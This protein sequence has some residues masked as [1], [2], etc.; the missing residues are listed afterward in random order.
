MSHHCLSRNQ[1]QRF[2]RPASQIANPNCKEKCNP[3][4]LR[5]VVHTS[6]IGY[7][8]VLG[9][10]SLHKDLYDSANIN[11]GWCFLNC[12]PMDCL[13]NDNVECE[14]GGNY[15]GWLVA[16]NSFFFLFLAVVIVSS[17]LTAQTIR[18]RELRGQRW[19]ISNANSRVRIRESMIQAS[20]YIGAFSLT[21]VGF[22]SYFLIAGGSPAVQEN[23]TMFFW[24]SCVVRVFL[25]LQ[26]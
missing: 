26:G 2:K 24:L 12:F 19:S 9:S 4:R 23:R 1:D 16:H 18:Q 17:V 10:I 14:R 11:V 5:V 6:A 13:R 7:P 8:I 15:E 3:K 20:L 22:G 21:Y 25:P